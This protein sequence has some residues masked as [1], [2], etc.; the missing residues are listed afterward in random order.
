MKLKARSFLMASTKAKIKKNWLKTILIEGRQHLDDPGLDPDVRLSFLRALECGTPVLGSRVYASENEEAVFCNTCKS[1]ACAACGHWATIH[2]TIHWQ[3]ERWCAL[4]EGPY[5]GVTL[6]MPD[7]L[8]S[9]FAANPHLTRELPSIAASAITIYGKV[10]KG[11]D[12]GV[13]PILHTFNGKLEFNS[14]V[15]ALVFAKNLQDR[16]NHETQESSSEKT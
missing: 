1:P 10:Y 12:I 5:K 8:R 14:H 15:H 4:P 13:M 11:I 3:R 2:C 7:T 16:V 9:L 6:T